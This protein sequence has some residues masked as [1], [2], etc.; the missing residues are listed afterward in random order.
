MRG[1]SAIPC[2][3]RLRLEVEVSRPRGAAGGRLELLL[4]LE[5]KSGLPGGTGEE[6]DA[7]LSRRWCT[8]CAHCT[9]VPAVL[10]DVCHAG[11]L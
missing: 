2:G 7:V 8:L 4:V 5:Y 3:G 11:C 9:R 6:A 1:D 10:N